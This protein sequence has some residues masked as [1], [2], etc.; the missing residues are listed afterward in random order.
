MA[1]SCSNI[2]L[3]LGLRARMNEYE[4]NKNRTYLDERGGCSNGASK[5]KSLHRSRLGG[6]G[7][8]RPDGRSKARWCLRCAEKC[9]LKWPSSSLAPRLANKKLDSIITT[10][11]VTMA[12][13]QW[14]CGVWCAAAHRAH[15]RVCV[16]VQRK[17][18]LADALVPSISSGELRLHSEHWALHHDWKVWNL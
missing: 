4:K 14:E 6:G 12:M 16:L 8:V 10:T 7:G 11:L 5:L 13:M 2:S 1:P 15:T 17:G 3:A 18:S 9:E